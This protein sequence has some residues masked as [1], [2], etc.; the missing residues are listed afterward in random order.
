MTLHRKWAR[1]ATI[2]QI[3]IYN[4]KDSLKEKQ[5]VQRSTLKLAWSYPSSDITQ[6]NFSFVVFLI[7]LGLSSTAWFSFE[8]RAK[9]W[10]GASISGTTPLSNN[11]SFAKEQVGKI[12]IYNF[13]PAEGSF[14]YG[15]LPVKYFSEGS[16]LST[17]FL[18][19]ITFSCFDNDTHTFE[20]LFLGHSFPLPLNLELYQKREA[21]PC[22]AGP[23]HGTQAGWSQT[24]R[25]HDPLRPA[26]HNEGKIRDMRD[27][28]E[29]DQDR[30]VLEQK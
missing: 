10:L 30:A 20:A 3:I 5:E 11:N 28:L 14:W 19:S 9:G 27:F 12:A 23:C 1:A 24:S 18:E 17:I 4:N 26:L 25:T 21:Y 16:F 6:S 29:D 22:W 7:P 8:I 15:R 13:S 2:L